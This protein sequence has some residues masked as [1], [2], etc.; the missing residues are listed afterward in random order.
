MPVHEQCPQ[1]ASAPVRLLAALPKNQG[2]PGRHQCSV[3]AYTRGREDALRQRDESLSRVGSGDRCQHG[4]KVPHGLFD[5][6]HHNQG[7]A[8]RHK[9]VGCAYKAGYESVSGGA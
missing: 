5:T 7:G 4:S 2:G 1:G 6:L 9:C 8:Q 3:C